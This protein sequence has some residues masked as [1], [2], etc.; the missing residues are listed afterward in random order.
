[1]TNRSRPLSARDGEPNRTGGGG[2]LRSLRRLLLVSTVLCWGPA[3]SLTAQSDY[4]LSVLIGTHA[5]T[6]PWYPAPLATR[7]NPAAMVGTDLPLRKGDRWSLTFG[8]NVGFV[9]DRWWMT[10]LSLEPEFGVG[11][12]LPAGLHADLRLGLG[13]MHYFWRRKSLKLEDGRY[14]GT[15]G[16]GMPSLVLPLSLTLGYRGDPA[17]PTAVA[18]FISARWT[19]QGLFLPEVPVVSR[20]SVFAGVRVARIAETFRAMR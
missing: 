4:P 14:V 8:I 1:M 6:V 7:W 3:H 11:R 5:L 19:A 20:F 15:T 18:P 12:H 13:Y 9:R 17:R 16:W 10:G 2:R